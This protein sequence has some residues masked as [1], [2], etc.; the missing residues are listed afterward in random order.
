MIF[1]YYFKIFFIITYIME[2][3]KTSELYLYE[4]DVEF[5]VRASVQ[6]EVKERKED[7]ALV[8]QS[9]LDEKV[10][11]VASD[12]ALTLDLSN[13]KDLM[14]NKLNIITTDASNLAVSLN[15]EINRATSAESALLTSL[16][17]EIKRAK[18]AENKN[19]SDIAWIQNNTDPASIDSI[20]ELLS[21]FQ[22]SDNS[23]LAQMATL[24]ARV[25]SL[26]AVVASLRG[27][28]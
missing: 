16:N 19:A 1:F 21:A 17:D 18:D 8:K 5:K 13:F 11:R 4:G 14:D 3:F 23:L 6:T 27:R 22:S 26:E 25:A 7:I 12:T 2:D 9:I 28:V 24:T 20:R 15:N 10:Q